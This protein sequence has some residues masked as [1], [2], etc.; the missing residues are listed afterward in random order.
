MRSSSSSPEPPPEPAA[1]RPRLGLGRHAVRPDGGDHRRGLSPSRLARRRPERADRDRSRARGRGHRLRG[2]GGAK[3]RRSLT[4]FPKPLGTG[5]VTSGPFAI[6][7]HPIYTG[8][9]A[10]FAGYALFA[11][12]PALILTAVLGLLWVGKMRVEERLLAAAYD[13]YA[14]VLPARAPAADPVRLL[15]SGLLDIDSTMSWPEPVE[16]VAVFLRASGAESRL[17][18]FTSAAASAQGAAEAIGCDLDQIVKSLVFICGDRPVLALVPGDRR[19]DP[20]KVG[21]RRRRDGGARGA[22]AGG[23][24]CDRACRR[25]RWGRSRLRPA[26]RSSSSARSS[27]GRWSGSVPAPTATW[28]WCRR[29]SSCA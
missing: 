27:R 29:S 8:G 26:C 7:R 18:E 6:V 13:G 14:A 20:A 9:L 24:R 15:T 17:E 23:R 12:V 3:P 4:P 1:D 16:R 19:A 5:L 2:L 11:S 10:F 21:G 22:A 28:R 25:E